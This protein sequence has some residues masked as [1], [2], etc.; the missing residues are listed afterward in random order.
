MD[1]MSF[2]TKIEILL[3]S[4]LTE[5]TVNAFISTIS[6][7]SCLVSAE[8]QMEL[9][10][11]LAGQ[12]VE[13]ESGGPFGAAVFERDNGRLLSVGV[14]VVVATK[15]SLA[16]AEIMALML[17]QRAIGT[18]DLGLNAAKV[19]VTSAQPCV[20]C[21]GAIW[22]SGI[23]KLVIGATAEDVELY[24]RKLATSCSSDSAEQAV[25]TAGFNE[26]PLRED[27]VECLESKDWR[28]E[29]NTLEVIRDVRRQEACEVLKKYA[30]HGGLIY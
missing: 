8:Q 3:P 18:Y 1:R 7:D 19:L 28:R 21:Y 20:Q 4:W 27:W 23:E 11:W 12:N 10:I 25:W 15:N 13:H 17:A 5:T 6:P 9:A 29:L 24:T 30:S 16:H 2:P 14:N 26:G 22:W